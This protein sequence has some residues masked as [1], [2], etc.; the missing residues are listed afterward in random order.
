M[1]QLTQKPVYVCAAGITL[2]VLKE[3]L[4]HNCALVTTK[5]CEQMGISKHDRSALGRR[6]RLI[7]KDSEGVGWIERSQVIHVMEPFYGSE[8]CDKFWVLDSI[9]D[10][11]KRFEIIL[12]KEQL[13]TVRGLA[14]RCRR[15]PFRFHEHADILGPDRWNAWWT[16]F[17]CL[18]K[19]LPS[20]GTILKQRA[21]SLPPALYLSKVFSPLLND[22][23]YLRSLERFRFRTAATGQI[24]ETLQFV[25]DEEKSVYVKPASESGAGRSVVRLSYNP[26]SLLLETADELLMEAAGFSDGRLPIPITH[27]ADAE[28]KLAQFLQGPYDKVTDAGLIIAEEELDLLTLQGK[29]A[30]LRFVFIQHSGKME[31]LA[32]Y[33]KLGSNAITANISTGGTGMKTMELLEAVS[34][35]PQSLYQELRDYVERILANLLK[36][37]AESHRIK[38]S[39]APFSKGCLPTMGSVD[40]ALSPQL[41]PRVIE[42]NS[43]NNLGVEGLRTCDP[44]SYDKMV[45]KYVGIA[46]DLLGDIAKLAD[47]MDGQRTAFEQEARKNMRNVLSEIKRKLGR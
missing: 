19:E 16:Y 1:K 24:R 42:V 15:L 9:D 12:E 2:P 14:Y 40:V 23:A 8:L 6:N 43:S 36:A 18:N 11:R 27:M 3:T 41:E 21:P 31:L 45:Y 20:T 46:N 22:I 28:A 30:E 33:A 34:G 47:I 13:S 44:E 4:I 25:I 35:S 37:G 7:V 5:E 29:R 39:Y 32:D 10:K 38:S 26:G 17:W